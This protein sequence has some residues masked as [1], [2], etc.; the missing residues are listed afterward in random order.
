MKEQNYAMIIAEELKSDPEQV[1]ATINLLNEGATVPFIA[2]YRKEATGSLDEVAIQTIRDRLEQLEELDKRREAICKSL[3]ERELLTKELQKQIDAAATMTELEDVYLPYRPKRRTR[4]TIAKEK[5]LEPLAQQIFKQDGKPINLT[6]FIDAEKGVEDE[7]AAWEG[8]KDIIAEW[9]SEDSRIRSHQRYLFETRSH[10]Q[11]GVVKKKQDEAAKFR[12]YFDWQE[13]LDKAPSHRILAIL[14]GQKEGFLT[15]HARPDDDEA[16]AALEKL[17]VRGH[18]VAGEKVREAAHDSYKRL[19]M[20]SLEGEVLKAAKERADREAISVFAK[21]LR[22]LLLASPI[23]QKRVMAIDPG[24]RTGCKVVILDAQGA[25]KCN[26]AIY[27][28]LGERQQQQAAVV[29]KKL[30]KEYDIEAIAVGNGTASRE[31]ESFLKDLSLDIPTVMVDESGASIYSASEAARE[32]FSDYDVTV[33]GSVSIGRRLQDPLAE[34]VKIDPKSI[35][36]GQY[37]HDVDQTALKKSLDDVVMSCVNAVGVEVNTASAQLLTY[38]SGLGPQLA[39][40]IVK[41]REENGPFRTLNELK[42][43]PRLGARTFEQAAGFLRIHNGKN[44]LDASAV[45]P[46]RYAL[47]KQMAEDVG[48]KVDDLL[49][50]ASLRKQIDVRRYVGDDVG[51]PTLQDILAEFDKPGRDPRPEFEMF[52]F[53]DAV[54]EMKDL[55]SGMTLPGIVTNVTNFGA[56]VDIGVHQDGLVHISQLADRFVKDPNDV[57]KVRQKVQVKVLDVDLDRK[58]ISLSMKGQS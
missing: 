36:V 10:L 28:T 20:P 46:E 39:K 24:F 35:G 2:R 58:R 14:R 44:P 33:R 18:G 26:T 40:N 42:K 1:E 51:L 38:V 55:R 19:L 16:V 11:S 25:L 23:G 3:Q 47:V 52:S 48:C 45:H 54:H 9:I 27:P 57:V 4:A 13:P 30:C 12:D 17:V 15:I 21:N 32:E 8:A 29:V 34:L 37:Q 41:F 49:H 6:A 22:E 31:T 7:N 53:S 5:G 56:F 43:V 50:D